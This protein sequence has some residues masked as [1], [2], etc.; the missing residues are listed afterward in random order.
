[1]EWIQFNSDIILLKFRITAIGSHFLPFQRIEKK[2][3]VIEKN[4]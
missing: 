4:I 1:M 3:K 2:G